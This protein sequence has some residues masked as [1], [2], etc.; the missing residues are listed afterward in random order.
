MGAVT[1][2]LFKP[3][4]EAAGVR[5]FYPDYG[6]IYGVGT[7]LFNPHIVGTIATY[8]DPDDVLICHSNGCAIAYEIMQT[9]KPMAGAVFINAALDPRII[10][11]DTVGWIDVHYNA[12][13]DATV[14]AK[15]AN[16]LG[17]V[18]K[19]W[20]EAGHVGYI[21]SDPL[22]R[23]FNDGSPPSALPPLSG[24]SDWFTP[25]KFALWGPW[26]R[27]VVLSRTVVADLAR[28]GQM[29]PAR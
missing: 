4:F 2:S 23:T 18:D 11:P 6:W 9:R 28:I 13:D 19:D 5:V 16:D 29:A 24:H 21:G 1:T 25:A 17:L 10:R 3:L 15:F 8:I 27:D 7:G 22:V 14:A 26:K 20:G 12:G